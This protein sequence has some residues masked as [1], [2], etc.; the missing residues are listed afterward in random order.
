MKKIIK[1]LANYPLNLIGLEIRRKSR[2]E[3]EFGK[4]AIFDLNWRLILAYLYESLDDFFFYKLV[5]TMESYAMRFMISSK[6][7]NLLVLQSN[8]SMNT[9]KN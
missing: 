1:R 9:S 6:D 4:E 3:S 5:L 2:I 7:I 8:Q